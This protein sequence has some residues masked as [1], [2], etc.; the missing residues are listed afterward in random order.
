MII[1]FPANGAITLLFQYIIKILFSITKNIQWITPPMQMF[2]AF[3]PFL[4]IH[5]AFQF[6]FWCFSKCSIHRYSIWVTSA[7]IL[8]I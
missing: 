4:H 1:I 5:R 3:M 6:K 2:S 8:V 7:H